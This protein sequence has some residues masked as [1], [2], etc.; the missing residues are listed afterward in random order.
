[1]NRCTWG[2]N[3]SSL[4]WFQQAAVLIR[5]RSCVLVSAILSQH[6]AWSWAARPSL[7]LQRTSAVAR[8]SAGKC[9]RSQLIVSIKPESNKLI[10]FEQFCPNPS[11]SIF[12]SAL[13][14]KVSGCFDHSEELWPTDKVSL[15]L[16]WTARCLTWNPHLSL[17]WRIRFKSISAINRPS[18]LRD[19]PCTKQRM[20]TSRVCLL[21]FRVFLN[22][23]S[24]TQL[25]PVVHETP[26]R[27]HMECAF[28]FAVQGLRHQSND[29]EK[30]TSPPP[31]SGIL[32]CYRGSASVW[33][34]YVARSIEVSE[35]V[36]RV[37]TVSRG[38]S[39]RKT[40]LWAK[41][42]QTCINA[43]WSNTELC[44]RVS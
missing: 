8:S 14:W 29:N 32:V 44:T 35:V 26:K 20:K 13:G 16:L 15:T 41:R 21:K 22:R 18:S 3:K 30:E 43:S 38:E 9:T 12:S 6:W 1:M 28:V 7:A 25:A 27:T 24:R 42:R 2:S 34:R 36:V 4:S 37:C 40:L 17:T 23:H 5:S 31:L 11:Q 39:V 19:R 33:C 10:Y